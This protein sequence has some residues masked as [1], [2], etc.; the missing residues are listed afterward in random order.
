MKGVAVNGECYGDAYERADCRCRNYTATALRGEIEAFP[1]HHC[2]S[3]VPDR[4]GTRKIKSVA[5]PSGQSLST[6]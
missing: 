6:C 3:V 5:E 2:V 1:E 4:R